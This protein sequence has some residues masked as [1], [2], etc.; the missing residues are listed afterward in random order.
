MSRTNQYV[1]LSTNLR[2]CD[3]REHKYRLESVPFGYKNNALHLQ[4]VGRYFYILGC[5]DSNLGM[6]GPKPGALPLGDTPT[7]EYISILLAKALLSSNFKA[8]G[9][10]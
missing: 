9:F 1:D 4:N 8:L 7:V 6:P 2:F 10:N 5:K 3:L